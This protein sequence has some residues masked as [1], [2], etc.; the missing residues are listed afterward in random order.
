MV[1]NQ[2]ARAAF[3]QARRLIVQRSGTRAAAIV[4][5]KRHFE[6]ERRAKAVL[7]IPAGLQA[8]SS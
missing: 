1:A 7:A 3:D 2:K 5:L 6:R 4:A 8:T